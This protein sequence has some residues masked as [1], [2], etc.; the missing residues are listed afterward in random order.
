MKRILWTVEQKPAVLLVLSLDESLNEIPPIYVTDRWWDQAV[1]MSLWLS[2]TKYLQTQH[3]LIHMNEQISYRIS[4]NL[5]FC[6][7][8]VPEKRDL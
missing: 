7:E 5:R 3:E 1:Y 8:T 4:Q 2:L 6:K